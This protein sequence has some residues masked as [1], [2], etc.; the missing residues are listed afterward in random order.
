[1]DACK[2]FKK[3]IIKKFLNQYLT[4]GQINDIVVENKT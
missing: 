4:N 3:Y 2:N 1:M